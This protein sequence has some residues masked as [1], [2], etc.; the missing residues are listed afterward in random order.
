MK[1]QIAFFVRFLRKKLQNER[2]SDKAFL[3]F[4]ILKVA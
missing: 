1:S 2:Y 3:N 4:R